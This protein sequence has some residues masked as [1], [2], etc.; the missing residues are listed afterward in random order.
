MQAGL[1]LQTQANAV[2][3]S[4]ARPSPYFHLCGNA[5]GG[6]KNKWL[7]PLGCSALLL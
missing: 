7:K 3:R 4:I 2:Q 5:K 6:N 1:S